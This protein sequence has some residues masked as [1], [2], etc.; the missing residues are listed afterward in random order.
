MDKAK[1]LVGFPLRGD[2]Y[3]GSGV[4]VAVLDTGIA[5]HPDLT[6]S[7]ITFRDFVNGYNSPY[8]DSG[9]GTHVCGIIG[10]NGQLSHGLYSGIAPQVRFVVGKILDENGDGSMEDMIRGIEWILEIQ[11]RYGIRI[12]NV[13]VG[14]GNVRDKSLEN[15]LNRL[16]SEAWDNGI[17]VVCA[18]G[19]NGP[20]SGSISSIGMNHKLITVG[21]H[22]GKMCSGRKCCSYYSGRGQIYSPVRKPDIVAPGTDIISCNAFYRRNGSRILDAYV[23]KSGTSMSTPMVSGAAALFLEK[24]P[25]CEGD[26][27]K[28]RLTITATDMGESWNRQGWGMINV[29]RLL[30]QI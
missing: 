20:Q 6:G 7:L 21:C 16:L 24:C 25:W 11:R 19:N 5:N 13:S 26:E 18:A 9:H 30:R 3:T 10:G 8:D 23:R 27:F 15:R 4:R 22:D 1:K 14:I 17:I 28:R 12:L 2:V 29:E